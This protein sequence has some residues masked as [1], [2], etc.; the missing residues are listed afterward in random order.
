VEEDR[1]R[2]PRWGQGGREVFP[3]TFFL[4]KFLSSNRALLTGYR[5]ENIHPHSNFGGMQCRSFGDLR[6]A[7]LRIRH[8]LNPTFMNRGPLVQKNLQ[9]FIPRSLWPPTIKPLCLLSSLHP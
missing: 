8:V 2:P 5:R 9:P 1:E 7:A 6:F 4:N 3:P